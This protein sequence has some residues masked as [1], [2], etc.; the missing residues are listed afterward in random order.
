MLII[1]IA[2]DFG[3]GSNLYLYDKMTSL[4]YAGVD[5]TLYQC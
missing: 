5:V 4:E 2:V 3:N 1:D